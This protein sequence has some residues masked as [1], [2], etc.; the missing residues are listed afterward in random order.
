MSAERQSV[1][2][3]TM[4][5]LYDAELLVKMPLKCDLLSEKL[6]NVDIYGAGNV[7]ERFAS[8]LKRR[9]CKVDYFVD[10]KI[11]CVSDGS[12]SCYSPTEPL[13]MTQ[14]LVVTAEYDYD[15]IAIMM[16]NVL[17]C[18]VV[19]LIDFL[20]EQLQAWSMKDEAIG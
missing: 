12:I 14:L 7:G 1:I 18:P 8:F 20:Q 15:D 19:A 3:K 4:Y 11:T 13:P 10:R 16:A 6:N 2:L 5:M 9:A 17:K